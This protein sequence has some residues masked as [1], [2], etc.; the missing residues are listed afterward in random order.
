MRPPKKPYIVTSKRNMSK[1]DSE[2]C[3]AELDATINKF[4]ATLPTITKANFNNE[5]ERLTQLVKKVFNKH[6]PT[7]KLTRKANKLRN[8]PRITKGIYQSIRNK[9]RL[10]KSHF[11]NGTLEKKAYYKKYANKL[12]HVKEKAKVAYYKN[13]FETQKHDQKKNWQTIGTLLNSCKKRKTECPTKL[14]NKNDIL[15]EP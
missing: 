9:Q 4:V 10:Y 13:E 6:A 3:N 11:R 5:F 7:E 1:F 15:T 2:E 8:K 14:I 12:T